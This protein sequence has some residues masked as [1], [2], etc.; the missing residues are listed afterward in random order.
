MSA[1]LGLLAAWVGINLLGMAA[2]SRVARLRGRD[3]H[4]RV[5]DRP[6]QQ[7][8]RVRP[9]SDGYASL[10]L[11]RLVVHAR[12]VLGVDQAILLVRE[13]RRPNHLIVVAAHGADDDL[14]GR[15]VR[16]QGV[17]RRVVSDR[18][19]LHG[20]LDEIVPNAGVATAI[21]AAAR[22]PSGQLAVLC[23]ASSDC[24]RGFTGRELEL[25]DEL[26]T[27][28]AAAI[29]DVALGARLEPTM[30]VLAG[31]LSSSREDEPLRRPIDTPTLATQVGAALGLEPSALTELDMAARACEITAV[32]RDT[33]E[34]P[35]ARRRFSRAAPTHI[36]D[37]LVDVPGL[38]AV[39][40]VVRFLAERWDGEGEPRGLRGEQIPLA[41]RILSG[42]LALQEA[43]ADGGRST[44]GALRRLSA[45]SGG[46][47]DPIVVEAIA[48]VLTPT[49]APLDA[50]RWARADDHFGETLT[51]AA[52]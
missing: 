10:L 45:Q 6:P 38:E 2:G 20:P 50:G 33:I 5:R 39:A 34:L 1:T 26:S 27:S 4:R 40:I 31:G 43:H 9:A 52:A 24:E 42:C 32:R 36:V 44:E 15:A 48:H 30:R 23:A 21:T 13:D 47:F 8:P 37:R 3:A 51:A 7:A 28:C 35:G 17:L 16:I 22:I 11:A 46:A 29:S 19:L 25:L 14:V 41:S 18:P 49:A 12:R